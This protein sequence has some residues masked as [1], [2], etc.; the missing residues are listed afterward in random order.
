[1]RE[2]GMR[3]APEKTPT[4]GRAGAAIWAAVALACGSPA[5]GALGAEVGK[6]ASMTLAAAHALAASGALELATLPTI[7]HVDPA[8]CTSLELDRQSN[9]TVARPCPPGGL[10]LRLDDGT[11]REDLAILAGSNLR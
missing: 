4:R 10:T 8:V 3:A 7:H 6:T 1:M 2:A 11:A 5:V 9:R